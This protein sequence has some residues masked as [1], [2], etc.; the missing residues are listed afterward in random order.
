MKRNLDEVKGVSTAGS[1]SA[2]KPS[3]VPAT[4]SLLLRHP[5]AKTESRVKAKGGDQ[6]NALE[7]HQSAS[8]P[9]AFTQSSCHPVTER[10]KTIQLGLGIKAKGSLCCLL[11]KTGVSSSGKTVEKV[12]LIGFP[13]GQSLF[14]VGRKTKSGSTNVL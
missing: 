14:K 13:I 4:H 2:C 11:L 8:D 6:L 12:F 3:K 7:K 5:A 9:F 10:N 1:S